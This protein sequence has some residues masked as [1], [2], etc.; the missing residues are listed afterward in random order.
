MQFKSQLDQLQKNLEKKTKNTGISKY[1]DKSEGNGTDSDGESFDDDKNGDEIFG[2]G[3]KGLMAETDPS[4]LID[5]E[6][7]NLLKF[8][9]ELKNK[10]KET[11]DY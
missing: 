4:K 10:F 2:D 6:L 1:L 7:V 8:C 9:N 5:L 11:D 3:D